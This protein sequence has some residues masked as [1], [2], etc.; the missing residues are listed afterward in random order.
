MVEVGSEQWQEAKEKNQVPS[1]KP[2]IQRDFLG[3]WNLEFEI[4]NLKEQ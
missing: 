3:S 1:F 2:Q 4:W